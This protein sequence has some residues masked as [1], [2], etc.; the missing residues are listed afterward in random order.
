MSHT[1]V[2]DGTEL[3]THVEGEGTDVVV[4]QGRPLGH[5]M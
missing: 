4:M 2:A 1:T 5:D 3:H